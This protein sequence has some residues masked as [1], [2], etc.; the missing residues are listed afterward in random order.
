MAA[1][2]ERIQGKG[3]VEHPQPF[4]A[5]V[6]IGNMVFTAGISGDDP[7]TH[8]V[9]DDIDGQAKNCFANMKKIIE[10]AGGTV[11]NI[12][13]VTVYLKD[14]GDRDAVNKRWI[15]VFPSPDQCP[16]R[17]AIPNDLQGNRKIQIEFIAVL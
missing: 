3:I 6:K 15:E 14:R 16:V 13:K 12:A 4:P 7:E 9:P 5:A 10:T 2:R 1:K 17:H 8:K 11:D